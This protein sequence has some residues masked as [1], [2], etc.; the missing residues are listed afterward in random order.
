MN[1]EE[2]QDWRIKQV[3]RR[4]DKLEARLWA[5]IA[6]LIGNLGVNAWAVLAK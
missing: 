3:E 6:L 4:M 5:I 2:L 1:G